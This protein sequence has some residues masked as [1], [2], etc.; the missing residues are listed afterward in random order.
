MTTMPRKLWEHPDPKSTAMWKF[1]QDVNRLHGLHLEVKSLPPFQPRI[2][3]HLT[4]EKQTFQELY[5]WS[6]DNRAAFFGQLWESQGWLQEGTYSRVVDETVPISELPRWFEGVRVNMTENFLWVRDSQGQGRRSTLGKEDDKVAI[7]EIREGNTEVRHVTWGQLRRR[8]GEM[9][10]A[11]RERGVGRGDR[12]VVV[13]AHSVQT[14]IVM[15][16]TLWVGGI[17][18]SSSTDMGVGGLLQRT[19]QITPK[20]FCVICLSL[21]L[22]VEGIANLL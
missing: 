2:Y 11:L 22:L 12:V 3:P 7:T 14:A 17:F 4:H 9:A 15:M 13:G 10:G 6:C 19:V 20:V 5:T 16:A 18:S 21:S 8:V 1:M